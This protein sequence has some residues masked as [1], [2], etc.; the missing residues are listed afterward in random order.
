MTDVEVGADDKVR[1][2]RVVVVVDDDVSRNTSSRVTKHTVM[3]KRTHHPRGHFFSAL[4]FG[5]RLDS[6]RATENEN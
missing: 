1:A 5:R 3:R 4:Q 6:P 2:V